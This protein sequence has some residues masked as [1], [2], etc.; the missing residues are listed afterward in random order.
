MRNLIVAMMIV[1]FVSSAA[2]GDE[3]GLRWSEQFRWHGWRVYDDDYVHP[4]ISAELSGIDVAA[5]AHVGKDHEDWEY[6]D[7]AIGYTFP[8]GGLNV[9]A[10]YDYLIFPAMDVQELSATISVPGTISP[11]YTIAHVMPDD[12]ADGQI[13]ILGVD[14]LLGDKEAVNIKL[15][16]DIT[17]NSGVN[18][19]G[20]AVRDWT[21]ATAGLAVN[22]PIG[23]ATVSPAVWYQ[24]T[25]EEA[26]NDSPDEVW[27]AVSL[28]YRF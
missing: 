5:T 15:M 22:V 16:G 21:H 8:V 25:I 4:G 28:S 17:F 12:A 11:R 19:F 2:F 18:P 26:I 3:I 23:K 14:A 13:H 20:P 10:G 27:A 9:R 24:H 7:T 6:W 1:L